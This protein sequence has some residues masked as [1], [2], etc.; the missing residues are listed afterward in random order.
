VR[1]KTIFKIPEFMTVFFRTFELCLVKHNDCFERAA[2]NSAS[3]TDCNV[4]LVDKYISVNIPKENI[5]KLPSRFST[6]FFTQLCYIGR[7]PEEQQSLVKPRSKFKA[8]AEF[9]EKENHLVFLEI[10]A[11]R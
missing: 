11:I 7:L 8:T 1:R 3:D 9:D 2:F 5:R 10:E 6:S 4:I